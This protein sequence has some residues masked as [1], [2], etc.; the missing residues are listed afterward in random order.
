MAHYAL[1]D[2]NNVVVNVIVGA[3]ENSDGI[4]WE[5]RYSS[6]F[7]LRCLRTSINTINGKH[8]AGGTPFRGNYAGIG[9][10]Y[11]TSL[12]AFIPP[13]KYPSWILDKNQYN[14]VSPIPY[15]QDK[16]NY[17]WNEEVIGWELEENV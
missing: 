17:F 3:E 4:N 10:S 8:I 12:N 13:K 11:N 1:L 5:K 14:W 9:Y 6:M 16:H 15:P 7:G 2:E